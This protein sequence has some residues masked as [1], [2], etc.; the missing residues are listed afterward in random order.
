MTDSSDVEAYFSKNVITLDF[1]RMI[2]GDHLGGGIGR[3]VFVY[4]PNPRMVIKFE[5]GGQSFQNIHEWTLWRALEGS[6]HAKW[7]A[8]CMSIS[9]C[10][11]ILMQQRT[12]PLRGPE[13]LP[14]RVPAWMADMKEDNWGLLDGRAVLHD[15]GWHRLLNENLKHMKR[16]GK[17]P[18]KE[19]FVKNHQTRGFDHVREGVQEA[20]A[21]KE[22][23]IR[24]P[25]FS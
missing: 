22:G 8:P 25:I 12:S 5:I 9:P 16:L 4:E 2:V 3:Q 15:Y 23:T 1:Y 13:E 10:G 24:S 20:P 6:E 11:S 19:H 18:L 17:N 21:G 7:I 14:D